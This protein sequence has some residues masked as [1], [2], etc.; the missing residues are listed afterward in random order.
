MP[1][2]SSQQASGDTI[3]A[4]LHRLADKF[5]NE[6]PS[7]IN[8]YAIQFAQTIKSLVEAG[9]RSG[10]RS[11]STPP[12]PDYAKLT[13]DAYDGINRGGDMA[14][15]AY[16]L[17]YPAAVHPALRSRDL[18]TGLLPALLMAVADK[19]GRA[20][21]VGQFVQ[22]Y[23]GGKQRTADEANQ[24]A[25]ADYARRVQQMQ[26][27]GA[28]EISRGQTQL[29]YL[30]DM[31]RLDARNP[32][33]PAPAGPAAPGAP[34]DMATM[35]QTIAPAAA[36]P[37]R[38]HSWGPLTPHAAA[39]IQQRVANYDPEFK[40]RAGDRMAAVAHL[41]R[42]SVGAKD[43]NWVAP[44]KAAYDQALSVNRAQIA[45]ILER[46]KK[47]LPVY[48]PEEP[49]SAESLEAMRYQALVEE[50]GRLRTNST[51]LGGLMSRMKTRNV[52][53]RVAA[54]PRYEN[55]PTRQSSAAIT[56]QGPRS[57]VRQTSS[58]RR[59]HVVGG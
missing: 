39:D 10:Q 29:G 20:D 17:P 12:P 34:A 5:P 44:L 54:S 30:N 6:L 56:P 24:A 14:A 53:P 59:F 58:G 28:N 16:S 55:S 38:L 49:N 41:E 33:A 36:S 42:Q 40:A 3:W 35:G 37:A 46:N 52:P 48:D 7:A 31:Q 25:A 23:M 15:K 8:D 51:Q 9:S 43:L 4:T 18:L 26:A 32:Q 57:A 22:Q 27:Q 13:R 21:A 19:H 11:D 45:R 47:N 50:G 2:A 1:A